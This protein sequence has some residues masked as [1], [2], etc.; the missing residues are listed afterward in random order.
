MLNKIFKNIWDTLIYLIYPPICP[1]CKKIVDERGQ[2]C[3][4]C[5]EKIYRLDND[6]KFGEVFII[7]KYRE[8]TRNFLRKLK[9][10][11]DVEVLPVIKKILDEVKNNPKL[12][13][14][15]SQAEI[16]TFVPLH[17]KRLQERGYNQT[18]LIF[19]D[20]FVEKNLP[21]ENFLIRH[22]STP[23]LYS[24]NP[25]ERKK[26]VQDAFSLVEGVNVQ[27]KKILLVDDI[28]TTGA[29]VTECAKVL[30]DNGA[31]KIFIMAFASDS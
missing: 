23:K 12:E 17:E 19:Q 22:K 1:F 4:S 28:F 29:T 31:E 30:K 8:G 27:G 6:K 26:I 25:E 16:A 10:D 21:S 5:L 24:Y 11:N 9:F 13:K 15:I 2:I 20:F 18:E 3:D 14:F 7:T